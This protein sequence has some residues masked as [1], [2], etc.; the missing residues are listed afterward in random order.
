VENAPGVAVG[1]VDEEGF[2]SFAGP[3]LDVL[4]QKR[5]SLSKN[6]MLQ[7]EQ[8][9]IGLFSGINQWLLKVLLAPKIQKSLLSA[10]REQYRNASQLAQASGVSI[11]SA[12][13]FVK[14]LQE[15][16]FL[17]ESEDSLQLVRV[18]QLMQRWQASN[19]S[20]RELRM[21]WLIR[22]DAPDALHA[23]IHKLLLNP[24]RPLMRSFS[25]VPG[26][27]IRVCAGLF[28]AAELLGLSFVHGAP[29]HL[30][31]E[32]PNP[33][34]FQL[35]GLA[36][37]REGESV[38]VF[39]RVPVARASIFRAAVDVSGVPASDV[40][41]IWLDVAAHPARGSAQAGEI[42]RRVLAPSLGV[43]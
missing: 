34:L 26:S 28:S 20:W 3:G 15:E 37:A 29:R 41:Q 30:Y 43:K 2:R 32:E 25:M 38:D 40:L 4:N 31:V 13:R 42:W 8:P 1:V 39:V 36:R 18:Q 24:N 10:P 12:F 7:K 14:Q 33:V 5:Q 16:S 22:S 9:K 21:R 17:H 6:M 35:L 23:A 27:P 11:M 19:P